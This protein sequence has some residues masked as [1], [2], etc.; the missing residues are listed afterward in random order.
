MAEE[1]LSLKKGTDAFTYTID[2]VKPL[3]ELRIMLQQDSMIAD[4]DLFQGKQGKILKS[5]EATTSIEKVASI[6][7]ETKYL[8][9]VSATPAAT[10]SQPEQVQ[11]KKGTA[12]HKIYSVAKTQL[13]GEFRK[14]LEADGTMLA[15]DNFVSGTAVIQKPA[16]ATLTIAQ[17]LGDDGILDISAP[18]ATEPIEVKKGTTQSK[19]YLVHKN[20]PLSEFK[21]KLVAEGVMSATDKFMLGNSVIEASTEATMTIAQALINNVLTIKA[22]LAPSSAGG[23]G[24]T[25]TLPTIALSDNWALNY[26]ANDAG[27]S[28]ID[29]LDDQD[30]STSRTDIE[31]YRDISR[32]ERKT[33]FSSLQ[34]ATGLIFSANSL[35]TKGATK[36][37]DR[38]FIYVPAGDGETEGEPKWATPDLSL[39]TE[40]SMSYNKQVHEVKK[41]GIVNVDA[42]FGGMGTSVKSSTKREEEEMTYMEKTTVYMLAR[43]EVPKV[44]LQIDG[45]DLIC[46]PDFTSAVQEALSQSGA[47]MQYLKLLDVLNTYGHFIALTYSVGGLVNITDEKVLESAMT[48]KDLKEI[49]S[50]AV[51]TDLTA[52]GYPIQAGGGV[53]VGNENMNKESVDNFRRTI[54]KEVI[55]G[56][57]AMVN[58]PAEWIASLGPRRNWAVTSYRDLK[59]TIQF[60]EPELRHKICILINQHCMNP[61]TAQKT[62]LNMQHYVQPLLANSIDNDLFN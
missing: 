26:S 8:T 10:P 52:A 17:A 6:D 51:E 14:T 43:Y 9:I 58:Q 42:S 19:T 28:L 62:I 11:V 33:L 40:L 29:T 60:L 37:F 24:R 1:V 3:A 12:P 20:Q 21:Q 38:P 31:Y 48:A 56:D 50:A 45:K 32:D 34:L 25:P 18:A 4:S 35:Q 55:G 41:R 30:R 54:K 13:L 49:Y 44:E 57:A 59:P 46:T 2:C 7:N 27:K 36:A 5:Q 53:G 23:S 47:L 22:F 15:T 16:E 61:T 39:N